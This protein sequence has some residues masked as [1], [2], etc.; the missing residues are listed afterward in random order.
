VSGELLDLATSL[1]SRARGPEEVEAYLT[2]ARTFDIRAYSGEIESVSSAQPRGAGVRVVSEGR[3]GFA[4]STDLGEAGLDA[5]IA[6]ARDNARHTT[7]DA[8]VALADAWDEAP[9]PLPDLVAETH[10]TT[11]PERKAAFVLELERV[12]RGQDARVRAVEDA[13]YADSDTEVALATSTGISGSYRRTDAWSYVVAIVGAEADTQVGFDF[14]LGRSLEA[15][16][17]E[18]IAR[19]AARRGLRVLGAT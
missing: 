1:A 13:V 15:L 8:A 6:A 4:F 11:T 12:T 3:M 2:H 9:A 5:L 19:R 7:P 14:D 10:P 16:D 17:A 18:T